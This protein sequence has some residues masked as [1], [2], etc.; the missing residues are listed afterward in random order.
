VDVD[1]GDADLLGGGEKGFEV[2]DMGVDSSIG[3]LQ[4]NR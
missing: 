2:V 3:D 1:F 4:Q